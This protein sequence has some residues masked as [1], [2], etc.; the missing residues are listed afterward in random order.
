MFR[1]NIKSSKVFLSG[2]KTTNNGTKW[3]EMVRFTTDG[4]DF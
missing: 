4:L 2:D 3:Y 1:K